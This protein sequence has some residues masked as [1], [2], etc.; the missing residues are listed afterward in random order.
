[1]LM[2]ACQ[3]PWKQW[4]NMRFQDYPIPWL[5]E[6]LSLQFGIS[7]FYAIPTH[8]DPEFPHPM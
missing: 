7:N 5:E 2:D 6:K 8:F 1:M 4:N 3:G